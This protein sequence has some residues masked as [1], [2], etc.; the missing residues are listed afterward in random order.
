M[1]S[2]IQEFHHFL[3]ERHEFYGAT[4][5]LLLANIHPCLVRPFEHELS[6]ASYRQRGSQT[7]NVLTVLNV[8]YGQLLR[9]LAGSRAK[10]TAWYYLVWNVRRRQ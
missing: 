5:S 9:M 4:E 6:Q 3:S 10:P 7:S 2:E 8:E 1:H